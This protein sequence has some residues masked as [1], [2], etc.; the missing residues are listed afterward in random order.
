MDQEIQLA[1]H[2]VR[3]LGGLVVPGHGLVH[4]EDQ[5]EHRQASQHRQATSGRL[6]PEDR[7]LGLGPEEGD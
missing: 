3:P 6:D 2:L 1:E 4:A 5:Q 7:P